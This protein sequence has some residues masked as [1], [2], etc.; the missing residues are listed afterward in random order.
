MKLG[1]SW[2]RKRLEIFILEN[3]KTQ[4][5]IDSTFI[6]E[7]IHARLREWRMSWR[8]GIFPRQE[9]RAVSMQPDLRFQTLFTMAVL[10]GGA[11]CL[12]WGREEVIQTHPVGPSSKESFK[13]SFMGLG[14]KVR[15]LQE[16]PTSQT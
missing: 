3:R 16:I 15:G 5:T 14:Q 13:D 6:S 8:G 12:L 2:N 4:N 7:K 9:G 11:S 1:V 10:E